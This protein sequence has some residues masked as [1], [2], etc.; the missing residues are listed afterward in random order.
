MSLLTE[1]ILVVG[2]AL[3]DLSI[4]P[5][6]P[7]R[8]G[9]DVR[10]SV[11]V[12][13]GGQGANVAVRL[14]RHGVRARLAC[15][16][17]DDGAGRL[18]RDAL[19]A[20]GVSLEAVGVPATGSVA[21]I[22][23]SD[24]ERTMLSQRAPFVEELDPA[25]LAAGA[26]WLVVSGY[27]LTESGSAAFA[28][29][30]AAAPARRAILGCALPP[31]AAPE[32]LHHAGAAQPHLLIVNRD[33]AAALLEPRDAG[34]D[35]ARELASRLGAI[36][37]VTAVD[38]AAGAG[39]GMTVAVAGRPAAAPVVDATGAGDA[40]A[41]VVLG[42]L[43]SRWPPS[44]GRLGEAIESGLALARQVVA[45]PGAQARVELERGVAT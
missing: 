16:L 28:A 36:V 40:F 7:M 15:G 34:A 41:A 38:R 45:A 18:L 27:A 39:S 1:P 21:V 43:G 4:M 6:E 23:G 9:A 19:E 30:C 14:A 31:G 17:A 2:D 42:E 3:L 12:A 29:R 26:Q 24:G 22:V 32:W 44:A 8:P 33:E 11:T 10:A 20:E 5:A 25:R 37:I 13:A 35:A